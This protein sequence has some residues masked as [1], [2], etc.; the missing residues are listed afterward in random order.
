[1]EV[2]DKV[3]I[4]NLDLD[5][6]IFNPEELVIDVATGSNVWVFTP[7]LLGNSSANV[8]FD[9]HVQLLFAR[10][11]NEVVDSCDFGANV[12]SI[13]ISLSNSVLPSACD[14]VIKAKGREVTNGCSSLARG[15][16]CEGDFFLDHGAVEISWIPSDESVSEFGLW[17]DLAHVCNSI[18]LAE[19]GNVLLLSDLELE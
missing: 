10:S 8:E 14:L 17:R 6:A 13:F 5:S 11:I 4:R 16:N 19:F 1:L 9:C 15:D 3:I 18:H 12:V 2:I 7:Y